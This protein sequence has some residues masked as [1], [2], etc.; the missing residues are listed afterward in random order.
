VNYLLDTNV[1]S[2][3]V[4]PQPNPNVV[5]WLAQAIENEIFISVCTLAELRLG[6][7]WMPR[8]RRRDRL[9]LWLRSDLP[10]RFDG[11][12]FP[13]DVAIADA[14]GVIQARSRRMGRSID[15]M[16]AL[17]AATAEVYGMTVVTRDTA[18]LAA[19]GIPLLNPWIGR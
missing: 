14:W 12:I 16:D 1:V 6:V 11:R 15:V 9:D 18:D 10:S 8:G 7:A 2:E 13:V 4:K 3:W 19:L 5:A 17:I